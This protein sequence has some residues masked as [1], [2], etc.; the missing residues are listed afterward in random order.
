M[1]FKVDVLGWDSLL[2]PYHVILE[3]EELLVFMIVS[4][5]VIEGV[6]VPCVAA[7]RRVG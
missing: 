1:R 5:E 3:L 2:T 4:A 7:A 6:R